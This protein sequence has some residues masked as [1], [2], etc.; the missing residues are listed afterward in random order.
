MKR[1]KALA[2]AAVVLLSCTAGVL[3]PGTAMPVTAQTVTAAAGTVTLDETTGTLT[4]SGAVKLADVTPYAKN[5]AV[6]KVVAAEG[7]VLPEYSGRMFEN[8]KAESIDLSK[9]D[10]SAV[11]TMNMMFLD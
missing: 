5:D 2:A 7:T 6:K 3:P 11:K 8:F 10:T 1:I 9:A 4:L